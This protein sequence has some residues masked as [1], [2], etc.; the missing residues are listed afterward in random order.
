MTVEKRHLDCF[1]KNLYSDFL[2]PKSTAEIQKQEICKVYLYFHI[3]ACSLVLRSY[4]TDTVS[5][6]TSQEI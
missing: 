6:S 5:V 1:S 3:S 2:H 4:A